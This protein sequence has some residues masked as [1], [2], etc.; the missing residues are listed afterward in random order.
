MPT[1][2]ESTP[3]HEDAPDGSGTSLSRG[4]RATRD[5]VVRQGVRVPA[6][7]RR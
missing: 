2:P 1:N 3:G 6:I 7:S 5:V 4:C